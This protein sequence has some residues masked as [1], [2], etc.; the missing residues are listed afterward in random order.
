[1][2]KD[3]LLVTL[4]SSYPHCSFGLRY[5][6]ANLGEF[7]SRAELMEFTIQK[8][9]RDI[10]ETLLRQ[11]AKIIGLGVYIWNA[12]E[13]LELVSLLKRISPE[14]IVVLGGPEGQSRI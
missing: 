9:P 6:H 4:N 8:D 10:A 3:I 11:K 13:S 7:A 1:M 5:L 2:G 12:Q 14:T